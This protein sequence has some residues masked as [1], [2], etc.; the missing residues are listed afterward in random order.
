MSTMLQNLHPVQGIAPV[1]DALSATVYTDV[2]NMKNWDSVMFII[3]KG[4]GTTGTSTITVQACDDTTPS[5][6]TAV[7]FFY[8][9]FTTSSS[10]VGGVL[11]RATASGF[12]TTAGSAHL[13]AIEVRQGD[14]AST[15]YSYVQLKAVEVVDDP[16]LAGILIIMGNAQSPQDVAA[17]VIV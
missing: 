9:V 7:P 17:S 3:Q 11:T 12:A 13:Y 10:D 4:V 5:N 16:V 15:G 14:L 2:V 8:K 6:R 1:A